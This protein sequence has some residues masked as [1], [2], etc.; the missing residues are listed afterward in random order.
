MTYSAVYYGKGFGQEK[1]IHCATARAAKNIA[2][3]YAPQ[4]TDLIVLRGRRRWIYVRGQWSAK[5]E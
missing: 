2:A 5:P 1:L 4:N 3:D